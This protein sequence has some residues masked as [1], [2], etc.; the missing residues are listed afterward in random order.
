VKDGAR[1]NDSSAI[2]GFLDGDIGIRSRV[3]MKVGRP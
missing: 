1:R 2:P 3:P